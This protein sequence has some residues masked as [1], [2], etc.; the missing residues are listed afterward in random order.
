MR[1]AE[2]QVLADQLQEVE[3]PE[4]AA[5]MT[6]WL[7]YP[8]AVRMLLESVTASWDD[9]LYCI[10]C[11][12]TTTGETVVHH[13]GCWVVVAHHLLQ[14]LQFNDII[15]A[16]HEEAIED[17]YSRR[18]SARNELQRV[19]ELK[20]IAKLT[21]EELEA[22]RQSGAKL[23]TVLLHGVMANPLGT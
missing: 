18:R 3:A 6:R 17:E 10:C 14:T 8:G 5:G 1:S 7:K 16:A 12:L 9:R 15:S 19:E 4:D 22:E 2:L 21:P 20:R 11:G 13:G 23:V